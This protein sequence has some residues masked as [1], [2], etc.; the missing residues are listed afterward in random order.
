MLCLPYSWLSE[1]LFFCCQLNVFHFTEGYPSGSL[2]GDYVVG[3]TINNGTTELNNTNVR[4]L[5]QN[6]LYK[7][8]LHNFVLDFNI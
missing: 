7:V 3:L 1:N 5:I 4:I 6:D 8:S 2:L